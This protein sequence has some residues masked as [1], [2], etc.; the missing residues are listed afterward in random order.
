[1]ESNNICDKP[2]LQRAVLELLGERI[3]HHTLR[4]NRDV[5][6][7][8]SLSNF[9]SERHIDCIIVKFPQKGNGKNIAKE[10]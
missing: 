1:M 4:I 2:M 10:L 7:C 3:V 5:S 9:F 8:I 6:T